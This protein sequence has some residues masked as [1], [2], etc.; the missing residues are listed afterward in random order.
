MQILRILLF[1]LLFF[2][3]VLVYWIILQKRMDKI[4]IPLQKENFL[5][6][7]VSILTYN[8]QKFPWSWKKIKELE[9]IF[10]KYSII[11]LQECYYEYDTF[12]ETIFPNF[13]ICR[14][15]LTGFNILNS[16]LVI[17]SKFPIIN[18]EYIGTI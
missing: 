11:L 7:N 1:I 13:Y 3:I 9:Q 17:L 12:L 6:S 2:L 8:I 5:P 4:Y 10:N 15:V 14:G 16:G 18:C